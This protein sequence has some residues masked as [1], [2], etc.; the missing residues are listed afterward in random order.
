M[1]LF[2]PHVH[3]VGKRYDRIS[4]ELWLGY[5]TAASWSIEHGSSK[6]HVDALSTVLSLWTSLKAMGI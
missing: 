1:Y 4:W 6:S 3:D 2:S 5:L